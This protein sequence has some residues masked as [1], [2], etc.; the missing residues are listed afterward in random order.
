MPTSCLLSRAGR[1]AACAAAALALL[2]T[3]ACE[4]DD[5]PLI[6]D[7]PAIGSVILT[8][9]AAAGGP[10]VQYTWN[11]A[12]VTPALRIPL[13]TSTITATVRDDAGA[14]INSALAADFE[15]R[16][17]ATSAAI[18]YTRS[19]TNPFAGAVTATAAS[20]QAVTLCIYDRVA[21]RCDFGS[22]ST[23]IPVVIGG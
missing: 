3:A 6:G 21:S 15:L 5:E 18:E 9:T 19:N 20:G 1:R 14:T 17:T 23:S 12:S 11:G 7:E 4:D 8:V 13:G 10:G 16:M 22:S 2:A